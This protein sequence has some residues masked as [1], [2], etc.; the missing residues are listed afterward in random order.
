MFLEN[1]MN[2]NSDWQA[3]LAVAPYCIETKQ[4]GD[5][6]LLKYN[7]IASDFTQPMVLEA[8]G[9]IFRKFA[10]QWR[11]VCRS[12][13]KFGNYGESYA[14]TN[15]MEWTQGVDVQEKIDGSIIR[16]WYDQDNWHISTNGTIDAFKAECGDSTFGDVFV[17][18][19]KSYTDWDSFLDTL[20]PGHTYWFEM[21]HPQYNRIVIQYNEPAIYFLGMRKMRTGE[22]NINNWIVSLNPWLKQPRHFTYASLAQCIEAARRMGADEEGYVCVSKIMKNG[23]YLRIKVKGDEYLA[24]HKMRG[25]G[26]LTVQRVVEM[27]QTNTLDDFIAY[28]P[29]YDEFVSKI[30][31]A[32]RRLIDTSDIAFQVVFGYVNH[33][34][35]NR[36]TFARYANSYITPIKSFLFTRLDN[37]VSSA[38]VYYKDMRPRQLAAH[39]ALMIDESQIG[40]DENE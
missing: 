20:L 25:N 36:R 12:L 14:P 24:L 39:I 40:V 15:R 5:Y 34:P 31:S 17:S 11:C 26:P 7:M 8:R 1:F 37:K 35:N 30:I 23:S 6:V 27:W 9:S 33:N 16:L 28:Y 29:E 3:K 22:E 19:V 4:D 18:I 13:D 10:G 32:I 2:A 38:A 21:V